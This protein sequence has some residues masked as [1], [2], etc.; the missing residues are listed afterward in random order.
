[1]CAQ[2]GYCRPHTAV[3]ELNK[4]CKLTI[5]T[6]LTIRY[7]DQTQTQISR[8]SEETLR[9]HHNT[10]IRS[11]SYKERTTSPWVPVF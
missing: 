10:E 8:K 7:A 2:I 11:L 4:I 9:L 5:S 1:M 3:F 6:T